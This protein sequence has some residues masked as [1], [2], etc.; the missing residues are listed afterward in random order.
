MMLR[1]DQIEVCYGP[2]QALFGVSL[3]V[4][5]G[6]A[7]ALLGRNGMGKSTTI[8]TIMGALRPKSGAVWFGELRLDHMRDYQICRLGF[9]YVPEGRRIF[10]HLT[11]HEQLVAFARPGA[12]G[13]AWT[14]P[15]IYDLFP[16]L[17]ERRASPGGL[18]SGGEQQMLAIG[19]A[20][21]TGPQIII[22]D[23]ATEGLAPLVRERIWDVLAALKKRG[24]SILVVDKNIDDVMALVDH[25]YILEK[26]AVAWSGSTAELEPENEEQR[27]LLA[28]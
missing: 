11:V 12:A 14:P 7:V 23:E 3:E 21:V 5:A 18:L 13:R 10:R 26:G 8:K 4:P 1:V 17:A 15:E 19:R 20:L 28:V 2:V 6:S 25:A 22:L 24:L 16:P 9:G 27:R